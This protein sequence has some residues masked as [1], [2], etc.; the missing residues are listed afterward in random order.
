MRTERQPCMAAK[1]CCCLLLLAAACCAHQLQSAT[2]VVGLWSSVPP[3]R[4][5]LSNK[6]KCFQQENSININ[7]SNKFNRSIHPRSPMRSITT[8]QPRRSFG[9]SETSASVGTTELCDQ[10]AEWGK[11]SSSRF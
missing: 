9:R 10:W 1:A 8:N 7:K 3:I 2:S 11:F 5:N 6:S 4:F